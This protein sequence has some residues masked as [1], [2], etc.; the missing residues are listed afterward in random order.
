MHL[1]VP[2]KRVLHRRFIDTAALAADLDALIEENPEADYVARL[3]SVRFLREQG[4]S[5]DTIE[6]ALGIKLKPEDRAR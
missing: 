2:G 4:L 6:A 3:R 5:N 1:V